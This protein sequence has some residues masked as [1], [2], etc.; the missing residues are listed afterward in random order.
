MSKKSET[1]RAREIIT[2]WQW[3]LQHADSVEIKRKSD[4]TVTV[5]LWVDCR[6]T[7]AQGETALTAC[8][9]MMQERMADK[10]EH[11]WRP[12]LISAIR[13]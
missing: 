13:G 10:S 1:E 11:E 3:V 5:T 2:A 8:I 6:Q 12:E 9:K 4:K 7:S